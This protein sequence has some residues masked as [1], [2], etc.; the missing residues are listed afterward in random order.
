MKA[1]ELLQ[2]QHREIEQ[3]LERQRSAPMEQR[4]GLRQELAALLVAHT[5]IEEE[6]FYPAL[7]EAAPELTLEALEEHA[8]A[9]YELARDLGDKRRDMRADARAVVLADVVTSHVQKEEN[10]LFRKAEEAL[11]NQELAELG[12]VMARRFD[13]VRTLGWK[14]FLTQA[15][16]TNTPRMARATA[17]KTAAKTAR[18]TAK[19]TQAAKPRRAAATPKRAQQKTARGARATSKRAAKATAKPQ[20]T[21][22]ARAGRGARTRAGR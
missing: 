18:K 19:K 1:T 10:E 17:Q 3:L 14:R 11:T 21:Q 15:V 6:H 5:V 7:R 12:E 22:A 4:E 16:V 20:K 8:L 13:Q 9:D 2:K